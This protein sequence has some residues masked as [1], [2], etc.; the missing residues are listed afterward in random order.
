M[1][2]LRAALTLAAV[3]PLAACAADRAPTAPTPPAASVAAPPD[4][5]SDLRR[6]R[7]QLERAADGLLYTSESDYPFT[8]LDTGASVASPLTIA[9]FRA[10]A[11]IPPDSLVE[12]VSLDAFLARHIENVDPGDA[13][14]IALVPRYERLRTTLRRELGGVT[15]FRVGRILIRCYLVGTTAGGRVAGLTTWAVE[16]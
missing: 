4:P 11:A 9:S 5:G 16:T 13:G 10:A 2:P 12:Q 7:R 15:V 3:A 6:L 8:F 14:A 1:R